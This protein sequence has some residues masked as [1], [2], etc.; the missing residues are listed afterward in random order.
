MRGSPHGSDDLLEGGERAVNPE[1]T[2]AG[3]H[4]E[5]R[6]ARER[7]A[8]TEAAHAKAISRLEE[9][10]GL[11]LP[12]E[13][14]DRSALAA[15]LVDGKRGPEAEEIGAEI[16]RQELRVEALMLAA[17][18]ARK[19]IGKLVAENRDSR[20]TDAIA[21]LEAA[22]A[23]LVDEATLIT[24]LDSGD[25][26]E[27]TTGLALDRMLAEFRADCEQLAAHPDTRRGGPQPEPQIDIG[28]LRDGAAA[29]RSPDTSV[30][31][32]ASIATSVPVP[33]AVVRRRVRDANPAL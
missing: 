19:Q 23:G 13:A 5:I 11:L 32:L 21:E 22:R 30:R 20:Y 17:D 10:R 8:N 2:A 27:A 31:S 25:I 6:Q 29:R 14:R 15:P 18:D 9:L 4:K 33:I 3:R 16:T 26:G 24:W 7:I 1:D 12:A 28:R